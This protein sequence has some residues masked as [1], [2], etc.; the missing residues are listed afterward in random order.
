[1]ERNGPDS[2][3]STFPGHPAFHGV[4]RAATPR[5]V[6]RIKL[7]QVEDV[8]VLLKIDAKGLHQLG[9]EPMS[10]ERGSKLYDTIQIDAMRGAMIRHLQQPLP[11]TYAQ[12]A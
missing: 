11:D 7:G 10:T 12:A 8:I 9:F 1:M 4:E 5:E 2:H 6:V 3:G